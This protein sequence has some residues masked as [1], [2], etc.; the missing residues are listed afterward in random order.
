MKNKFII[1]DTTRYWLYVTTTKLWQ[2]L[3]NHFENNDDMYISSFRESTVND[4]DIIIVYAKEKTAPK[5]GFVCVAQVQGDQI[6]NEDEKIKIF[7]DI[8]TNDLDRIFSSEAFRLKS[9]HHAR[10]CLLVALFFV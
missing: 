2:D 10:I 1:N 6:F 7:H 3:R 4:E 5:N 8:M 9:N